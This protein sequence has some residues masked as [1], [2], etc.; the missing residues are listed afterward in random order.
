MIS[1][2]TVPTLAEDSF[3]F[4]PS[5]VSAVAGDYEQIDFQSVVENTG[6]ELITL[7]VGKHDEDLP[8]GW[9]GLICV[10]DYCYGPEVDEASFDL[11]PGA[12]ETL[13]L[14]MNLSDSPVSGSMTMDLSSSA[15]DGFTGLPLQAW[16]SGSSDIP[17]FTVTPLN[18]NEVGGTGEQLTFY[19][20]IS[21]LGEAALSFDI[22]KVNDLPADWI[23]LIC[24]GVTC[25]GPEVYDV[26]A[27]VDP[28]AL[29]ILSLY[30]NVGVATGVGRVAMSVADN[31]ETL[32][33]DYEVVGVHEDSPVEFFFEPQV[34]SAVGGDYEQLTFLANIRNLAPVSQSFT[35]SKDEGSLPSGWLSMICLDDYCYSP[36]QNTVTFDLAPGGSTELKLY[37]NLDDV[38]DEGRVLLDLSAGRGADIEDLVLRAYHSGFAS[39]PPFTVTTVE[40]ADAG[41]DYEQLTYYAY[42]SN[43]G[44]SAA[45]FDIHK[46][47]ALPADWMAMICVDGFCYGPTVHDVIANIAGLGISE[48][49]VYINLGAVEG[50]G[51]VDMTVADIPLTHSESYQLRGVHENLVGVDP[52]DFAAGLLLR[53]NFPNPFNPKTEIVFDSELAGLATL[54]IYSPEGR[55]IEQRLLTV[56]EGSNRLPFQAE[57]AGGRALSSGVYLYRI[58]G[59]AGQATG[60]ML[61]LK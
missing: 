56:H 15:G 16:H 20:Y 43:L 2:L 54:L 47:E 28:G 45:D 36:S 11:A 58:Q 41:A 57:D 34:L 14:Y 3:S 42:I 40:L 46:S 19:S 32:R 22:S 23:S 59:D 1:L 9:M 44:A 12:S 38:P 31:P 48:L 27:S 7:T 18:L 4:T 37:V 17:D 5:L 60:R 53:G 33:E 25:Y 21:N 10:G 51:T 52:G 26:M 30:M 35:L 49:R 55:L 50:V 61:L 6:T 8:A 29:E 39:I 13:H 24:V